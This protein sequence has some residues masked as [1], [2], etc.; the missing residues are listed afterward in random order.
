AGAASPVPCS[1]RSGS[2]SSRRSCRQA[3]ATPGPR[4]LSTSPCCWSS[5]CAPR[6]CSASRSGGAP[7]MRAFDRFWLIVL[8][9]PPA[10]ALLALPAFG[11]RMVVLI[12][13][14]GLLG[15]SY[16]LTFGHLGVLNLAQGAFFGV[17]A[18]ATALAAPA[19]GPLALAIAV[20]AAAG[21]ALLVAA[22]TL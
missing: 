7:E 17:G 8:L 20:L 2:A 19:A 6:V 3:S 14:Y 15:V 12:G 11:Q 13:V 16:Q 18:Y 21:P 1:V 22:L 10:L 9:V 5:R 4:P